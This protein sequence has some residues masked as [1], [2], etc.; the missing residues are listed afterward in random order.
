M[1]DPNSFP[2]SHPFIVPGRRVRRSKQWSA[3]N[4]LVGTVGIVACSTKGVS[5]VACAALGVLAS[6]SCQT[7]YIIHVDILDL[8][9][10][11]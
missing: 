9:F 2:S 5:Y 6:S 10:L 1:A 8:I 11:G 7:F 4:K 3:N